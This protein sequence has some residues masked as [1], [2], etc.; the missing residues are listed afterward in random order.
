M[1]ALHSNKGQCLNSVLYAFPE[2]MYVFLGIIVN[3]NEI[4]TS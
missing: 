3:Q 2:N 1:N 4:D